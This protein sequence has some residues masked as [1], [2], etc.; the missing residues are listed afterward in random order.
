MQIL[1]SSSQ[2]QTPLFKLE[3][4]EKTN[5]NYA[6]LYAGMTLVMGLPFQDSRMK[7]LIQ[8]A[9]E[10]IKKVFVIFELEKALVLYDSDFQVHATLI[11]IQR[12]KEPQKLFSSLLE[13][14][15]KPKSP[16]KKTFMDY[17]PSIIE[18]SPPFEISFNGETSLTITESGQFLLIGKTKENSLLK[19]RSLFYERGKILHRHGLNDVFYSVI[20]YSKPL[21]GLEN[22]AF[23]LTL[24]RTIEAFSRHLN[25]SLTIDS[26]RLVLFKGFL[27]DQQSCLWRSEKLKLGS[28]FPFSEEALMNKLTELQ[29]QPF[30]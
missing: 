24:R 2:S 3:E 18:N 12:E 16:E 8:E 22:S 21:E 4:V 23:Q 14:R 19:M 9:Q 11:E 10:L 28:A 20:A 6:S 30:F 26:L 7:N 13:E 25:F 15:G 17:A 27:L 29:A 5:Q 1:Q